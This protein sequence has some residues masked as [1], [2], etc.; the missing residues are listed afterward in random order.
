MRLEYTFYIRSSLE[1]IWTILTTPEGSAQIFYGAKIKSTFQVDDSIQYIGPGRSGA[2]TLHI[3]GKIVACSAPFQ[4]IHTYTIG[5]TYREGLP[6]YTS[7]VHYHL[8]DLKFAVKLTLI[9]D[10]WDPNDPA[11]EN[12]KNGWWL[13][14]SNIKTL[15]E[16]GKSLEIGPHI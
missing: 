6:A 1:H 16:T 7:Q 2:D 13:M 3:Y 9:H 8:E 15:A 5:E 10:H 4:L 12:T 14:L 11:Y